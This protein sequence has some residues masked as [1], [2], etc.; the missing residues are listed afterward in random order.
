M[1]STILVVED[2]VLVARDIKSRL[3]RMGYEVLD[4]ARKGAEAIEK[5]LA[6]KPDLVLMD[7]H[8][9]DEIDGIEAALRIRETIDVPVIFCTA[10]ADEE[11]L[12]RAKISTPY[13]YVLKPFDNRELEINIEIALY[14]H[15]IEI[16]LNNTRRRLDA[17]LTSISDGVIATDMAG[18]ICLINPM[19]E[20]ITGWCQQSAINQNLGQVMP[21]QA[22]EATG[23]LMDTNNIA[24]EEITS[25]LRQV[26]VA[27]D[28]KLVP[29]EVSTN[30]IKSASE[31]LVVITFR[32]ISK[33]IQYEQKIRHSAFYDDLTELP[34][35]ALFMNRLESSIN[36]RKR[37]FKDSFAAVLIDLDGF[38]PIH[39]GLGHEMGDKLLSEVATRIAMTVRPDDTISRFSADI[40]AILLDPVDSAA[41]AIQACERIQRAIEKPIDL[42]STTVDISATAGIVFDQEL[43]NSAEEMVRDADTAIH[44]AK[45]D[46]KGAYV[47]F[48][49]QMYQNALKFIERK[50]SMQQALNDKVFTVYYQPIVDTLTSKLVS[51]EALVRWKDPQEGFISPV[52]FIPIAEQTGLIMPLGEYVLRSV[53]EQIKVWEKEGFSGFS[54]AV[55]LSL[56]QFETDLP[57]I[58]ESIMLETGVSASAL[59]LEITEG[60][61]SKNVEQNVQMLQSLRS[62]GLSI[63]IDDF[64]TGYSSLAYLK[65]FPLN[66]LKIDRSFIQD[67]ESNEDDR[68]ITKAIIA[69][70]QNLKLKV[71]AE[72]VENVEQLAILK[73]SGCDYIQGYYFSKP[74][75][76][77][78]VQPFLRNNS[79]I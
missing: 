58:I 9:A 8:L 69:M 61:A 66:T 20:S 23:R 74:L 17:T 73:S 56:R 36:R 22:F 65:R 26:V 28:G 38:S 12:E 34:N 48:D 52:E 67:I 35:R 42:G 77:N 62:L 14:K 64:G 30:F 57:S 68:E 53:C 51:M 32:D 45:L 4:T 5:A 75:P 33:Q 3:I 49:N 18:Q 10:Y 13:G 63:S 2:E 47:I 70:G 7:I 11:T 31:E 43:Y 1:P 41:G 44:R 16:D 55:N 29:I 71:L 40:F 59:S 78:E 50:S 25:A 15:N 60:I 24:N 37:G 46:A 54:V 76:P 27:H 21:L 79:M 72:G 39:E 6:L 19:A